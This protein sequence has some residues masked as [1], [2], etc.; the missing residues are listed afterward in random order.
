MDRRR[1]ALQAAATATV[2]AAITVATARVPAGATITADATAAA[3][4]PAAARA[5]AGALP[6]TIKTHH[7]L[8][9]R[10][11]SHLRQLSI[12]PATTLPPFILESLRARFR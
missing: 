12:S 6:L 10:P 11:C 7:P 8:W 1:G 9:L 5:L 3:T 4:T 2:A